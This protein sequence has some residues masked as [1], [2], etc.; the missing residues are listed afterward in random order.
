M[1]Q[2]ISILQAQ[3]KEAR[4]LAE[5]AYLTYANLKASYQKAEQEWLKTSQTFRGLDYKLAEL[6]G[7][8]KKLAPSGGVE[9]KT[10]KQPELTLEQLQAIA[11]KLGVSIT[12]EEPEENNE[13]VIAAIM[14]DS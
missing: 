4:E 9:R 11:V 7:R 8:L 12:I 1:E 14:E 5:E 10:Q 2:D 13:E 6:D 3:T